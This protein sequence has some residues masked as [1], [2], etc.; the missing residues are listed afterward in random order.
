[1]HRR[2]YGYSKWIAE[3]GQR[4]RREGIGVVRRKRQRSKGRSQWRLTWLGPSIGL[5]VRWA[6]RRAGG[7]F[8]CVLYRGEIKPSGDADGVTTKAS[9]LLG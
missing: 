2:E 4:L 9:V 6:M 8:A 3:D 1:M 5:L 7:R